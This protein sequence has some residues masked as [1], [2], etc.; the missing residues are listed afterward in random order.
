MDFLNKTWAQ[1]A[2][3][4]RSMSPGARITTA[5]LLVVVVMSLGYLF[6]HPSSGPEVDLMNG[7]PVPAGHLAAM[8]A[9]FHEAGLGT[10][11]I[12]G[13]RVFVP[14]GQ[15][16]AYMAA[17]AEA[18]ALPPN[19]GEA[20]EQAVEQSSVFASRHEKQRRDKVAMQKT[21][22]QI[23]CAM[24]GIETAYVIYD[25]DER[26]GLRREKLV[27]ATASAKAVGSQSL[28]ERQVS[29]IR[30]M[31]AGAIAGLRPE[32]VTVADLNGPTHYGST[33][34]GA[35]PARNLYVSLKRTYEQEWRAKI[36]DSLSYIRGLNVEANVVLDPERLNRLTKIEYDSKPVAVRETD[37]SSERSQEGSTP[38]GGVGLRAQGNVPQTLPRAATTGSKSD[39]S[40]TKRDVVSLPNSTQTEREQVGLTPRRV[41]VAIGIPSSYVADVWKQQNPVEEGQDPATPDPAALTTLRDELISKIRAHVAALL[42]LAEGVDD[43]KELVTVTSFQDIP[44]EGPPEPGMGVQ[45]FEWVRTYWTTLGMLG[46]A[47]FS[48][49]IL[50]S[51]IKATP[52]PA[53]VTTGPHRVVS[54][55][56]ETAEEETAEEAVLNRLK[57]FSGSGPSLR[58]ELSE[59]VQEDPDTAASILRNWIGPVN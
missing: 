1:A 5:L 47:G 16:P 17:L 22:S 10:Y 33:E 35:D 8:E 42:P 7:V 6:T 27:T 28:D 39:E 43:P 37:Q 20:L 52:A 30:H 11:E 14:Q 51:M 46:L 58:D 45:I 19:I 36:L 55:E 3:L 25:E 38:G 9:A 32:N 44:Q 18:K 26:R 50:R 40:Q 56:T 12:R 31:V 29:A 23:I 54:P 21:L 59:L 48:L 41:S 34:G 24:P 57:R 4:F 2:D 15:K 13:T 49:V 53:S